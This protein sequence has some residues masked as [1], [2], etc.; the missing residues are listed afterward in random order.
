MLFDKRAQQAIFK[1]KTQTGFF[2]KQ[3]HQ[4]WLSQLPASVKDELFTLRCLDALLKG[5]TRTAFQHIA[6]T[7]LLS[8]QDYVNI[9]FRRGLPAASV[10]TGLWS[11]AF[12]RSLEAAF[13]NAKKVHSTSSSSPRWSQD[14]SHYLEAVLATLRRKLRR[15]RRDPKSKH[16]QTL[17][18]LL[19]PLKAAVKAAQLTL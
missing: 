17:I 14:R 13:N 11:A 12:S 10:E 18:R 6:Q 8:Y 4:R 19:L 16:S 9:I 7:Y 1:V 2:K 15:A 5:Q 3:R